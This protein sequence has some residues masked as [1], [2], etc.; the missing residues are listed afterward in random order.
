MQAERM[1]WDCRD[2]LKMNS[3]F[4]RHR[5]KLSISSLSNIGILNPWATDYYELGTHLE[6]SSGWV[7]F[8]LVPLRSPSDHQAWDSHKNTNLTV[9]CACAPMEKMS[10]MK[11]VF[12]DKKIWDCWSNI[13]SLLHFFQPTFFTYMITTLL[14]DSALILFPMIYLNYILM[15]NIFSFLISQ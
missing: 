6:V 14:T 3:F 15:A 8:H 13:F 4:Q 7:K 12:G 11:L 5:C 9:N 10:S 1:E 2:S